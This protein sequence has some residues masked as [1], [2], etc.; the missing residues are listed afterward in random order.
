MPVIS[1]I[2]APGVGKSFLVKQLACLH[3][4][5]AFFE[6]EAGVFTDEVLAVL[7]GEQDTPQRFV[8]LLDR[9]KKNL[10][11]AH[12][13]SKSGLTCFVDGD[14]LSMEAWLH[15]EM[16]LH[17]PAVLHAWIQEN[18][19]LRADKTVILLAAHDHIKSNIHSR[20]RAAELSTF[21]W[22]RIIRIQDG[23]RNVAKKHPECLC[24]DR[25]QL[26]FTH[27]QTL[28]KMSDLLKL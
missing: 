25:T 14:V 27:P 3:C 1:I 17:S 26:D 5:P 21:I 6:G 13:A 24:I 28:Y 4:M 11:A 19:H 23:M 7:N 15:A 18:K 8:W 9:Y 16:G 2:G 22:Q 12:A 10:Q 20:G